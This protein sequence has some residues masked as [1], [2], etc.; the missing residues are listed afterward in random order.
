MIRAVL[1]DLDGTLLDTS[2]GIVD[3]ASFAVSQLGYDPLPM[4]ALLKFVGPP[5]QNSLMS[6]LGLTEEE[7][8]KG[9]NIFRD[10]Y[11]T[12]ALFKA[13]LYPGIM[14]LLKQLKAQGKKIGV[15]TYKREDYAMDLLRH[16]GIAELCDV[17]HGA[18]NN[19]SLTKADIVEM[20]IKE[21]GVPKSNIVLVGDTD[22]DAKGAQNAGIGF[23]AVT[24]GFGYTPDTTSLNYDYLKIVAKP[25][26][27]ELD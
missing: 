26:E 15:A 20:C 12:K 10:Y 24:W 6:Y 4:E 5:I 1:F 2:E 16:F 25:S 14:D 17:I 7:A 21:I 22:H 18:D 23:I 27:L 19:N 3:S 13:R 8:Q 11:K 9:A